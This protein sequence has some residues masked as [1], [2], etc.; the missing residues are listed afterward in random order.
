MRAQLLGESYR[1][2]GGSVTTRGRRRLHGVRAKDARSL[3]SHYGHEGLPK[4]NAKRDNRRTAG[5]LSPIPNI[6]DR[7]VRSI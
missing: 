5:S 1:R 7:T 6:I 2:L 4:K 3:V